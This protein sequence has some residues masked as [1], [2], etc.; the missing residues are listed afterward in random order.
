MF[1]TFSDPIK[2]FA[3]NGA[4]IFLMKKSVPPS[5]KPSTSAHYKINNIGTLCY[6]VPMLMILYLEIRIF[7]V[8][9]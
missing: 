7:S 1:N 4:I 9:I 3:W 5:T 8:K 6:N 2:S